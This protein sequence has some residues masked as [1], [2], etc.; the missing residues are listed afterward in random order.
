[1]RNKGRRWLTKLWITFALLLFVVCIPVMGH[2]KKLFNEKVDGPDKRSGNL[3]YL[4]VS[5]TGS[6]T[7]YLYWCEDKVV[8]TTLS[9]R[10]TTN[11]NGSAVY[12][13]STNTLT[14]N[15][16]NFDH[17]KARKMGDDFTIK[18]V[19]NNILDYISLEASYYEYDYDDEDYTEYVND[20]SMWG[21]SCTF[22]G[23]SSGKLTVSQIHLDAG[24][25]ESFVKVAGQTRVTI[26]PESGY[27]GLYAIFSKHSS[28][29]EVF[30]AD[31]LKVGDFDMSYDSWN[32][33]NDDEYIRYYDYKY[34]GS[35]ITLIGN[36]PLPPEPDPPDPDPDPNKKTTTTVTPSKPTPVLTTPAK[37]SISSVKAKKK[38]LKIKWKKKSCYGYQVQVSTKISFKKSAT[39]VKT[40]I[41]GG[42][43]SMSI[44]GLKKKRTYFVRIRTFNS[45]NGQIRYSKWSNPKMRKTK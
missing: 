5:E 24:F 30:I 20:L 41:G 33:P 17:V 13:A 12:D 15:N 22:K 1:M 27:P 3:S 32:I 43:T 39:K 28:P 37:T 21:N 8:D 38:G 23:D 44:G 2:A 18:L 26:V 42:K 14:L 40:V 10:Y 9:G 16:V 45:L 31:Q 6:D 25:T 29:T 35:S 4:I 11:L 19:G 7:Q 36:D 34:I